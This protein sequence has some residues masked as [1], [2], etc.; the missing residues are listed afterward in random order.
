MSILGSAFNNFTS[1]EC[2]PTDHAYP[3][4]DNLA[5]YHT[6]RDLGFNL[7]R[8][9]V[10]WQH[11]QTK[12]S[13]PLNSTN[14]IYLDRMIQNITDDGNTV[15]LDIHNY[16]RWYCAVINQPGSSYP[17]PQHNVTD[18][19]FVD[20]WTRLAKHY[21]SHPRLIFELMNEPHDLDMMIWAS[22]MQKAI[23][24][25]RA[26]ASNPILVPGTGFARLRDWV[27]FS[28]DYIG[29]GQLTDPR[30]NLIYDFH[31]YF[32]DDG[33]AYGLCNPWS[34]FQPAFQQVTEIL[35]N[36]SSRGMLTEFGGLPSQQCVELF[37]GLLTFLNENSDVWESWSV[38]GDFNQG[39]LYLSTNKSD[40]FYTL[41][42]VLERFAPGK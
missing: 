30:N 20:L 1:T 32:D 6:W 9:P 12:L 7:F 2:R 28:S 24:A 41:T 18:E 31:Q 22:T 25:I 26:T 34:A 21:G 35:R 11:A 10:A 42:S 27:D 37:E 40:P 13:G 5:E 38:W 23:T 15:I 14:M 33:G 17:K 4:Y 19:D 39:D 8:L 29:P 16:A 36:G 3:F